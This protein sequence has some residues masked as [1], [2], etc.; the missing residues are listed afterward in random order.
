[1]KVEYVYPSIFQCT[2]CDCDKTHLA[3][4]FPISDANLCMQILKHEKDPEVKSIL[5]AFYEGRSRRPTVD[6][7][8]GIFICEK[9]QTEHLAISLNNHEFEYL[10]GIARKHNLTNVLKTLE[11]VPYPDYD[12][13]CDEH[14]AEEAQTRHRCTVTTKS[15]TKKRRA[16]L[17]IVCQKERDWLHEFF[18]Y[19]VES[20]REWLNDDNDAEYEEWETQQL[21]LAEKLLNVVESSSSTIT[22]TDDDASELDSMLRAKRDIWMDD[23]MDNYRE[24]SESEE[25]ELREDAYNYLEMIDYFIHSLN[26]D[27]RG[28]NGNE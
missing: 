3:L 15:Y 22:M 18:Q 13:L 17:R 20:R 12:D 16:K 19:V 14:L 1:M 7:S 25:E 8:N 26:C 9:C 27:S 10:K 6:I 21:E 28:D 23:Y 2:S 4:A 11:E 24:D 5:K